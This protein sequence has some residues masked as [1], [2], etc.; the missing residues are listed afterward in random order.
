M[1]YKISNSFPS[2]ERFGMTSQVRRAAYGIETQI[3][4]GT[5][6]ITPA[7]RKS[8]YTR[9]LGSAVEVDNFA[10][11]AFDLGYINKK[12][13]EEIVQKINK[14][15]FLLN[16]LIRS[17]DKPKSPATPTTLATPDTPPHRISTPTILH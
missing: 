10:L 5:A 11:I 3:A 4:E 16:R 12:D 7:H 15:C 9:A 14:V 17:L 8:Y 13:H 2:S 1:A 6:M